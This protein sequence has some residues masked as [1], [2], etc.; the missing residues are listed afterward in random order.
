[1]WMMQ[2]IAP[3]QF[4]SIN[5]G[6]DSPAQ[7]SSNKN[8]DVAPVLKSSEVTFGSLPATD[9]SSVSSF[10]FLILF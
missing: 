6:T 9:A 4:G 8:G 7:S 10:F 5:Q 1:M 3:I 2:Y